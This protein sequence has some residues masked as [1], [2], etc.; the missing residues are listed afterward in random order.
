V[1]RRC[2][3]CGCLLTFRATPQKESLATAE[4]RHALLAEIRDSRDWKLLG[5]RLRGFGY[6]E[7]WGI[8][9]RCPGCTRSGASF[10]PEYSKADAEAISAAQNRQAEAPAALEAAGR[11]RQEARRRAESEALSLAKLLSNRVPEWAC[12]LQFSEPSDISAALEWDCALLA[13]I[14]SANPVVEAPLEA[15]VFCG[16][17]RLSW[18]NFWHTHVERFWDADVDDLGHVQ[19]AAELLVSLSAEQSLVVVS[20]RD[21]VPVAAGCIPVGAEFPPWVKR[22][23]SDAGI[24]VI[25]SWRGSYDR[26]LPKLPSSLCDIGTSVTLPGEVE[27]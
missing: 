6:R 7:V 24:V 1:I 9:F 27:S 17:I 11:W 19:R 21:G 16:E 25:R 4:Q 2:G 8:G 5:K 26:D 12:H 22:A 23:R 18:G 20:Y 10:R 13:R 14:P 3:R 15:R